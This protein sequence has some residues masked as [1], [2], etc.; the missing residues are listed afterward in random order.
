MEG[1]GIKGSSKCWTWWRIFSELA[2]IDVSVS[3]LCFFH[4]YGNPV[5]EKKKEGKPQ[6]HILTIYGEYILFIAHPLTHLDS[7]S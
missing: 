1:V 2:P 6:P 3:S 5:N 7:R 4:R